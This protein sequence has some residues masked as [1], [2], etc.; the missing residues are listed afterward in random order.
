MTGWEKCKAVM[1]AWEE[2]VQERWP[3][4]RQECPRC[5]AHMV[6]DG[7]RMT[8]GGWKVSYHVVYPW[9][10]FP[11]NTMTLKNEAGLLSSR[12]EF[13]YC[14]K[15][16]VQKP[17][18]DP[19]VYTNNRQFRMLLNYKLSD[20]TRPALTLAAPPTLS[21]FVLSC[22]THIGPGVWRVP[23]EPI[24][25]QLR[26]RPVSVSAAKRALHDPG[27]HARPAEGDSEVAAFIKECL[28]G[29]GHPEG[30][31]TRSTDGRAYRWETL[32]SIPRPC[33]TAQLWRPA[34][35]SH[36]SNGAQVTVNAAGQIFLRCLHS[37]CRSKSGGQRW[38][39]GTVP[40]SL[41]PHQSESTASSSRQ[42]SSN[43]ARK[44]FAGQDLKGA[45][46]QL[47][48]L[49]PT[50]RR[51][52]PGHG[53]DSCTA[54][55]DS[56]RD[57][58]AVQRD[59]IAE[60]VAH[61]PLPAKGS[62]PDERRPPLSFPGSMVRVIAENQAGEVDAFRPWH[63]CPGP[64][65]GRI[66]GLEQREARAGHPDDFVSPSVP[67]DATELSAWSTK[68]LFSSPAPASFVA[69][70][71]AELDASND[72]HADAAQGVMPGWAESL[73]PA[74]AASVSPPPSLGNST[75]WSAEPDRAWFECPAFRRPAVG[76]E[77]LASARAGLV[78][79]APEQQAGGTDSDLWVDPLV[80]SYLNIGFQK[81]ERSLSEI[82]QLVLCHR[83]DVLFLGDLG[84]SRNKIGRLK[85]RLERGRVM[86]GSCCLTSVPIGAEGLSAWG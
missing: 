82:I 9:L 44:R 5:L 57:P 15:D 62:P 2:R 71:S 66:R 70:V 43:P 69:A 79:G 77:L 80:V 38:Y 50:R 54:G 74:L 7:S 14:D 47:H 63:E 81:L 27:H 21:A 84:V 31:L 68:P 58:V 51:N 34:K 3:S 32:H 52:A 73:A 60:G 83:P 55:L 76:L 41:L 28:Y 40:A 26:D 23:P 61:T 36:V 12:P 72:R 46:D 17:F 85:Q 86:S 11:C 49:N 48:R 67:T 24:Q 16:N 25:S 6:L 39:V 37:E 42:T 19:A 20:T 13:Q 33:P 1:R 8:D 56:G 75:Q 22:I 65:G 59:G 30:R 35:P 4:A 10:V 29:Q 18:V 78:G 53:D 45:S 64:H